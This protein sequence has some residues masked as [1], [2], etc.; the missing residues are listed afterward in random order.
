MAF[1]RALAIQAKNLE[2]LLGAG[3]ALEQLHR[4]D[5]AVARFRA[6]LEVDPRNSEAQKGLERASATANGRDK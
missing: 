1:E 3:A 6:A 2:A 5:E 4:R